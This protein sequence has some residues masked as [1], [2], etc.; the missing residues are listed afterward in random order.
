MMH[1]ARSARNRR[2]E[3]MA[4]MSRWV[5]QIIGLSYRHCRAETWQ[6]AVN[7]YEDNVNYYAVVD[8][9]GV[10]AETIDLRTAEGLL[11]LSGQRAV[12]RPADAGPLRLRLMEIDHGDFARSLELPD[13]VDVD[14]IEA[15][16]R[17]GFLWIRL[18]KR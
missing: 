4:R 9:A 15:A 17:G 14:G 16:Y 6:P 18:P 11:V 1:A 12:P 10:Q 2:S 3:G 13:D 5:D 8:L 7:L